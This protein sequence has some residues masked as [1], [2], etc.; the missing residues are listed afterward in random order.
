VKDELC[1]PGPTL[2][3]KVSGRSGRWIIT[4]A[5]SRRFRDSDA[6][7]ANLH[8]SEATTTRPHGRVHPDAQIHGELAAIS[9]AGAYAGIRDLSAVPPLCGGKASCCLRVAWFWFVGF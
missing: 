2:A 5:A 3:R 1:E 6:Y 9:S 8:V 4:G 7:L